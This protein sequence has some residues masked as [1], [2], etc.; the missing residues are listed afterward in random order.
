MKRFVFLFIVLFLFGFTESNAQSHTYKLKIQLIEEAITK[1][2]D[3][4][5]KE[6]LKDLL[7]RT[8][9]AFI[10]PDGYV[11]TTWVR[12]VK[13]GYY[14]GD[15]PVYETKRT[16]DSNLDEILAWFKGKKYKHL[17]VY[18][19]DFNFLKSETIE[20][21]NGDVRYVSYSTPRLK[22]ILQTYRYFLRSEDPFE[23]AIDVNSITVIEK[24]LTDSLKTLF[25][26]ASGKNP[27]VIIGR[28]GDIVQKTATV[29]TS[30]FDSVRYY[31][32][33]Q[34]SKTYVATIFNNGKNWP[35]EFNVFENVAGKK[36]TVVVEF[37]TVRNG[38]AMK[39]YKENLKVSLE[40]TLNILN[41][42]GF[43]H[44]IT[45]KNETLEDGV[46]VVKYKDYE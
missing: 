29:K 21:D 35:H 7:E 22:T 16:H 38:V 37:N 28:K 12:K 30:M 17:E 4:P 15:E 42:L 2:E 25:G 34:D 19:D 31:G 39:K 45:S 26:L 5:E 11:F 33:D 44:I 36:D 9:N 27:V 13:T 23:P 41:E 14:I 6:G 24:P 20:Y 8:K 40:N 43:E 10:L 1:A 46:I 3:G 18:C 32:S